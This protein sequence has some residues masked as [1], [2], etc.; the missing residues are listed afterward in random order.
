MSEFELTSTAF[1][2]GDA[3]PERYSCDGENTSPRLD[4]KNLPPGTQSLALIVHD[5]DAPSGD[6]SH[7]VAWD[8]DPERGHIDEG[9]PAPGEGANGRGGLGYMGPCPPPG[10]G[11][12]RYFHRLYALDAPLELDTGAEKEQL[13]QKLEGHVLGEARLVGIY[14]RD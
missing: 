6:F 5:P 7:W 13:K 8:I 4:W 2:E 1:K 12:H 9:E 10:H 3:I 14:E 11:A